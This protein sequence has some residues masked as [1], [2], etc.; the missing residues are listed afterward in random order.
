M[1]NYTVRKILYKGRTMLTTGFFGNYDGAFQW[2]VDN[3]HIKFVVFEQNKENNVITLL[4]Q[5]IGIPIYLVK[6]TLDIENVIR[7]FKDIDLFIVA[8]FGLIFTEQILQ[9]PKL[10]TINFHPGVLPQYRGR[11]PL[12][13]AILNKDQYMGFTSHI[14]NLSIDKGEILNIIRLPIDYE[15]TYAFNEEKLLHN[16]INFV[17]ETIYNY[18]HNIYTA[19][20]GLS[21]YYKPLDKETLEKI[22]RATKLNELNFENCD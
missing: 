13:Q 19:P 9:H 22:F 20:Q 10:D 17:E 4:C 14:M 21:N 12:P 7:H 2:L 3:T 16:L 1:V 5:K 15:S 18:T 6:T 8:S 11:H